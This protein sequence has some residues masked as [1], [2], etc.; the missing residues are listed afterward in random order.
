MIRRRSCSRNNR[1]PGKL[2][3]EDVYKMMMLHRY[4]GRSCAQLARQFGI[5]HAQAW[6][7]IARRQVGGCC[8]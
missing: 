2:T 5:S 7:L 8:G 3:D 1:L 4:Q 6:D